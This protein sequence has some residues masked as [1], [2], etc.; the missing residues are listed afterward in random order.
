MIYGQIS[1]GIDRTEMAVVLHEL[2]A[3]G[4]ANSISDRTSSGID[5]T[6]VVSRRHELSEDVLLN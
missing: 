2:Y 5:H 3:G 4:S 6:E 1:S